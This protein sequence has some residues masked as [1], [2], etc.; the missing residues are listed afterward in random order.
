MKGFFA[1]IPSF[2]SWET[3]FLQIADQ[4]SKKSPC[5]KAQVGAVI[6]DKTNTILSVGF[7]NPPQGV[8]NC[9]ETRFCN[10]LFLEVESGTRYETCPAIHA[11]QKAI[12]QIGMEKTIDTKMFVFGHSAICVLCQRFLVEA[13]VNQVILKPSWEE[14]TLFFQPSEW[15]PTLHFE[16]RSC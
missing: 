3:Y 6:V 1:D 9:F 12:M 14:E 8:Q 13:Q 16:P 10:R 2:L 7:N 11:E 5:F 15:I 4:V